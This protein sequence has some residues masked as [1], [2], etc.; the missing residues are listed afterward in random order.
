VRSG[1]TKI[2][3]IVGDRSLFVKVVVLTL[4]CMATEGV[5]EILM[6]TNLALWRNYVS[7]IL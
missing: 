1:V 6:C 3:I 2:V 5:K 4:V 7:C